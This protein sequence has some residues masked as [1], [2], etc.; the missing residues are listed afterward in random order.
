MYYEYVAGANRQCQPC[1][2]RLPCYH[3]LPWTS[4]PWLVSVEYNHNNTEP[5]STCV[6]SPA[7]LYLAVRLHTPTSLAGLTGVQ[8]WVSAELRMVC[9]SLQSCDRT[10]LNRHHGHAGVGITV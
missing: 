2:N 5:R 10:T 7:L 3:T 1:L 8:D 4:L 9:S 6:L